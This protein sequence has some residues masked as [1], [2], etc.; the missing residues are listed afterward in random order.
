MT[1]HERWVE[2]GQC[3]AI[4]WTKTWCSGLAGHAGKHW[5]PTDRGRGRMDRK[6]WADG[7]HPYNIPGK[8]TR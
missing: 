4:E 8:K 7:D 6:E 2:L 3:A 1:P 5:A